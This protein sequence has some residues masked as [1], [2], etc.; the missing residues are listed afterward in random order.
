MRRISRPYFAAL[1]ALMTFATSAT[2][3]EAPATMLVIDGSGSMWGELPPNNRAK[4]DAVVENLMPVLAAVPAGARVGVTSYGHRRKSD[5]SD[6]ETIA[7]VASAVDVAA[8]AIAKLSPRGKGPLVAG[9]EAAIADVGATRPA[10]LIVITDGVDNCQQ[11]PCAAAQAIAARAPGVPI[12]IITMGVAPADV[13]R[14]SCVAKATGGAAFEGNDAASL[15]TAIEAAAKLAMLAPDAGAAPPPVA[16]SP[17]GPSG[18][19]MLRATLSLA[20]GGA[21]LAMPAHWRLFK[22]GEAAAIAE[23]D[24]PDFNQRVEAGAYEIEAEIGRMRA[25][26]SVDVADAEKKAVQLPLN[27]GRLTIKAA[28]SKGGA[29]SPGAVITI[30]PADAG[31]SRAAA[32]VEHGG[33]ADLVL[34]PSS[35]SVAIA[36]SLTSRPETVTLGPGETK[37]LDVNLDAGRLVLSA[38]GADGAALSD[39]AFAI[40]ADD[41][42][43]PNGRRDVARSRAANA[44]FTLPAGTYYVEAK[45]GDGAVRERVAVGAGETVSR[46]LSL[47]LVRLSLA[48]DIAGSP[49]GPSDGIVYRIT[50]LDGEQRE[51]ARSLRPAFET[52]LPPGRYRIDAHLDAH[53]LTAQR[54]ITLEAG[55]PASV[56]IEFAAAQVQFKGPAAGGDAFWE[57]VDSQGKPVWRTQVANPKALLRPGRYTVR[58]ERRDQ[59]RDMAFEVKG[60]EKRTVELP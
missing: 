30:F 13:P 55:K 36:E 7:G 59:R 35:Y 45:S 32:I 6:A 27:A 31:A 17:A 3:A 39:V 46:T 41:P 49:A 40:S 56:R 42:E 19:T 50:A 18:P 5:C 60:G 1:A 11:D 53:H 57:V 9:L 23:G 48:A 26:Q 33:G 44:D 24:G 54:E 12:H 15:K 37:T 4:I 43:S 28:T 21:A 14:L 8:E 47:P 2:A 38:T 51:A 29:A 10:N 58:Y 52:L 22:S 16:A 20:A 25:R 34:P